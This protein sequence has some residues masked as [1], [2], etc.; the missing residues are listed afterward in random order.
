MVI[1]TTATVVEI[2]LT[3]AGD[4][5]S[6]DESAQA[7][8][9]SNL[10]GVLECRL[11]ACLLELRVAAAGSVSISA[12]L[13]IPTTTTTASATA[14]DV[15]DAAADLTQL[16]IGT[17]SVELGVAVLAAPSA[18]VA[19]AQEVA[20]VV[21]PPPP[22][23]P[24]PPAPHPPPAALQ[25]LAATLPATE[26]K[27]VEGEWWE[28]PPPPPPVMDAGDSLSDH[29]T[30]AAPTSSVMGGAI[31]GAAVT[32]AAILALMI[33]RRRCRQRRVRLALYKVAKVREARSAPRSWG[34][35]SRSVASG[36]SLELGTTHDK[37]KG[38]VVWQTPWAS[39]DSSVGEDCG[40]SGDGSDGDSHGVDV[41]GSDGSIGGAVC[42]IVKSLTGLHI[43]LN[44]G[45]RDLVS[46]VKAKIRD[47]EAVPVDQQRL[48]H[49]G[50][51]IGDT[52][53]LEACGVRQ[54]STLHLIFRSI[55]EEEGEA[56]TTTSTSAAATYI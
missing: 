20:I 29:G 24:P 17:L 47:K 1:E 50:R 30:S 40:G 56:T 16:G 25:P 15:V 28:E 13:T 5:A 32:L 27:P 12:V 2:G 41:G 48:L 14:A 39:G 26:D 42:I 22:S 51:E 33:L 45:A 38:G 11:P 52:Q 37:S 34:I 23:L 4:V 53:M 31:V 9:A 36:K 55:L 46:D 21:A 44:V 43:T 7:A 35:S 19:V 8:L 54:G 18:V 10:R 3:I 49:G 6:F